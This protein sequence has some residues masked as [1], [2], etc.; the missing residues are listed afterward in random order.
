MFNFA[1]GWVIIKNNCYFTDIITNFRDVFKTLCN[2]Y[3][4]TIC[5]KSF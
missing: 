4:G 1:V 3:D 5:K 2:T